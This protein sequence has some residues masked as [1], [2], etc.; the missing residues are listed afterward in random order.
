MIALQMKR[1][2]CTMAWWHLH[3]QDSHPVAVTHSH[4]HSNALVCIYVV[5]DM[6][7]SRPRFTSCGSHTLQHSLKCSSMYL[8]RQWWASILSCV[9]A[10]HM[11]TYRHRHTQLSFIYCTFPWS[12]LVMQV[13]TSLCRKLLVDWQLIY[14]IS[15]SKHCSYAHVSVKSIRRCNNRFLFSLHVNSS[16][17]LLLRWLQLLLLLS[18]MFHCSFQCVDTVGW[19]T[20]RASGL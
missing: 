10:H 14:N 19:V 18:V 11:L 3:D 17:T 6:T 9:R 1:L 15:Q 5:S 16:N 13:P 2:C 20:G 7:S 12:L 8:C 4:T